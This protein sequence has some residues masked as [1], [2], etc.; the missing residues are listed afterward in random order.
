ME[1]RIMLKRR[2][3]AAM[4]TL[5]PAFAANA[6]DTGELTC[7]NIGQL[8]GQT[9]VAKQSGIP[10]DVYLSALNERLPEGAR[11][12]R[13]LIAA[14]TTIIYQN[15][16]LAGMRP[17]DA[18]AVFQQDCMRAQAENRAKDENDGVTDE[19]GEPEGTTGEFR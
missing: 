9:V 2:L 8:A 18:Y 11:L 6:Y 1:D 13:N 5:T 4:L 19:D 12:E 14:I 16:L 17:A 3:A 15:D 10:Q 7:D